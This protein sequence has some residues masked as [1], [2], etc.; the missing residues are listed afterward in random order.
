MIVI[1]W[2]VFEELAH[3]NQSTDAIKDAACQSRDNLYDSENT[4][5]SKDPDSNPTD[6]EEYEAFYDE[7]MYCLDDSNTINSAVDESH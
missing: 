1:V 5:A 6:E 3:I 7:D 4:P 2:T